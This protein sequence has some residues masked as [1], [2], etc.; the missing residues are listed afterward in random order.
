MGSLAAELANGVAAVPTRRGLAD[1]CRTGQRRIGEL[2][3]LDD[4]RYVGW[5]IR[6]LDVRESDAETLTTG[7]D[8]GPAGIRDGLHGGVEILCPVGQLVIAGPIARE[9]LGEDAWGVVVLLDQLELQL[10][11]VGQR[12]G[13][14]GFTRFTA[15]ERSHRQPPY[16]EPGAHSQLDPLLDSPIEIGDDIADLTDGSWKHAHDAVGCT[17]TR[18]GPWPVRT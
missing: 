7:P 16:H 12:K 1:E 11:A 14:R 17:T 9:E 18:G 10:A 5:A 13:Q 4:L 15:V 3:D 8:D 2:G 6:R